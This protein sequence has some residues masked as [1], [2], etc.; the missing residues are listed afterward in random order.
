MTSLKIAPG[1]MK[2]LSSTGG[3]AGLGR[4]W[5]SGQ[6]KVLILWFGLDGV[7]YLSA[8]MT[9]FIA[10]VDQSARPY[11]YGFTIAL[12]VSWALRMAYGIWLELARVR[13]AEADKT[14]RLDTILKQHGLSAEQSAA[15]LQEIKDLS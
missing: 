15:V 8:L 7:L 2:P 6:G 12:V 3:S 9:L 4:L 10:L 5:S 14:R 13:R 1:T 11:A